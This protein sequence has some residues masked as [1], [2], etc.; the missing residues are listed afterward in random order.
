MRVN[1]V[2]GARPD[3]KARV[4]INDQG[5]SKLGEN[6]VKA[7]HGI[8]SRLA[9]TNSVDSILISPHVVVIPPAMNFDGFGLNGVPTI[10]PD[11]QVAVLVQKAFGIE[12]K[13]QGLLGIIKKALGLEKV[14]DAVISP[15]DA[16]EENLFKAAQ[17][18]IENLH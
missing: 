7:A 15:N 12:E 18:A 1:Y 9:G 14:G 13:P 2:Q 3:F 10:I 6:V 16:T 8:E 4:I 5:L 17:E 11:G